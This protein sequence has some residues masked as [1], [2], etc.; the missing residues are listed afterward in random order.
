MFLIFDTETTG[1]PL[2]GVSPSHPGQ[3]R[4]VQLAWLLLDEKFQEVEHYNQ[5]FKLSPETKISEGAQ[6]AHGKSW[7]DCN[8]RGVSPREGVEQFLQLTTKSSLLI[9]HNFAFDVQL[10]E[11]ERVVHNL[12]HL[13]CTPHYCTM[14]ATTPICK[15]PNRWKGKSYK[16]P[17]LQEAYQ[18][19][20]GHQ[21]DGA[22][23]ALADVRATAQVFKWL[24]DNGHYKQPI[25]QQLPVPNPQESPTLI[26]STV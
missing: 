25:C 11:I 24:V 14:E 19:C 17:K 23:D 18:H 20:Y 13:F 4:I 12:G 9:A 26:T 16:W 10:I 15:L 7:E 2:K 22:H 8:L 6:A 3:A 5:L 21:F 1:F